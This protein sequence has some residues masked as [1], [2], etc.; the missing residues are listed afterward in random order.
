[1]DFGQLIDNNIIVAH[2]SENK[3]DKMKREKK[4]F[5]ANALLI[6]LP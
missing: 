1:M 3:K 4:T 2:Y 5:K 6:Y